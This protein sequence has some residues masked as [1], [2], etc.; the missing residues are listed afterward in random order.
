M[1]P[2]AFSG[3][4]ALIF[5]HRAFVWACVLNRR[6]CRSV[7]TVEGHSKPKSFAL[8]NVKVRVTE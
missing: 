6:L 4:S 5:W 1:P 2:V 8:H 3:I 7:V